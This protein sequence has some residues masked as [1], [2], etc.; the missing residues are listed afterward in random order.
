MNNAIKTVIIDDEENFSS[1]MEIILKKSFPKMSVLGKA[2]TVKDG[3]ALVNKTMPDLVFLDINLP[4]GT[5]FDLLEKTTF[6]GF[7]TVFTT[8]Y[9]EYAVR[10][11]EVSAIHYLL[12]PIDQ[13]KLKEAV[14]RFVSKADNERLDE[15]LR[16][17]KESLLDKPQK[18]LLPTSE[19]QNI[20]NISEIVRCEADGSYSN[21]FFNNGEKLMISKPLQHLQKILIDL[22]F[23]RIHNKHLVNMKF[24]KKYVSGKAPKLILTD[25]TELQISQHQ[26]SDFADK[27]KSYVKSL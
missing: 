14:D 8:S 18:I 23:V 17:L 22:D 7:E 19:G 1:S 2:T 20:F 26:K 27:L 4:D 13:T 6:N 15:K 24:V 12:K 25:E 10:A 5:G 11:F 16:I 21:V 9:S 3:I